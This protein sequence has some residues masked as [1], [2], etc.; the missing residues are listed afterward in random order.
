MGTPDRGRGSGTDM[1]DGTKLFAGC[2]Q[3]LEPGPDAG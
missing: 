3:M 1:N 2:L